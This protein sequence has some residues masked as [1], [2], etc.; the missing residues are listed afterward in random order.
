[1]DSDIG[2][3]AETNSEAISKRKKKLNELDFQHV[4][5]SSTS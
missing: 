2:R 3:N 4:N 1:M 5:M